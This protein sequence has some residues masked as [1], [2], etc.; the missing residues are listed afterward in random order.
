MAALYT[1][2]ADTSAGAP[3]KQYIPF[4]CSKAFQNLSLILIG[5]E[6]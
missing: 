3:L 2:D 5:S 1:I 6:L 4:H